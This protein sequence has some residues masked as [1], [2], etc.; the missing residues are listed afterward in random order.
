MVAER[1]FSG[2]VN[3][4]C[5]LASAPAIAPIV[6]LERCMACLLRLDEVEAHCAGLRALGAYP[7]AEGFLRIFG[8]Q[9]LELGLG[10]LMLERS[11]PGIAE[12]GGELTQEFEA[13]MSTI[14]TASMRARGGSM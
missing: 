9:V 6:S 14:R 10:L 7:M 8:D 1:D 2:L 13:L 3:S 11:L 5:A 4:T 12:E